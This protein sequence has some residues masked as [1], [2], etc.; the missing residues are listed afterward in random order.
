MET[1]EIKAKRNDNELVEINSLSSGAYD[2]L[3]FSIRLAL[4][5]E[6]LNGKKGFLIL[7]DPF[8]K[9]DLERLQRQLS[10]LKRIS[11]LEWQI[12]Y[13]SNKNEI[14]S[15][16]RP[17]IENQTIKLISLSSLFD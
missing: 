9:S 10:L 17:D 8:I 1:G 14:L 5:E 15:N 2:Q 6:V 11:K 4:A 16:F 3:Y 12:L 13:F 7:D